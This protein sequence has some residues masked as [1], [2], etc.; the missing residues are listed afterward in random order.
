M[1]E[2]MNFFLSLNWFLFH[3]CINASMPHE[4]VTF[5]GMFII[6]ERDIIFG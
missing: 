3:M 6:K 5:E 2:I 1:I 4:M